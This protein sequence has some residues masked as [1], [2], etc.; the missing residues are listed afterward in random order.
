M[1]QQWYMR[2]IRVSK[3]FYAYITLAGQGDEKIMSWSGI[4]SLMLI[5]VSQLMN[6]FFTTN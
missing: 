1:T 3:P 5:A 6:E 4:K 2:N